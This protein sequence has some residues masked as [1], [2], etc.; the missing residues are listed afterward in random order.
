LPLPLTVQA[1]IVG[2]VKAIQQSFC[3]SLRNSRPAWWECQTENT[4]TRSFDA[5]NAKHL[6]WSV[7]D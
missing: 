4:W 7:G 6:R 2:V 1:N 3:P 5:E